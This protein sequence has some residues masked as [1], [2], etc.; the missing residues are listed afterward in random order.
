MMRRRGLLLFVVLLTFLGGLP[1]VSNA[2]GSDSSIP[3]ISNELTNYFFIHYNGT[4]QEIVLDE[5][6]T[7]TLI[8]W[9]DESKST[10]E[11]KINIQTD[12]SNFTEAKKIDV[13]N[14]L[15]KITVTDQKSIYYRL[16]VSD[17][18]KVDKV[19]PLELNEKSIVVAE[20]EN[21]TS[22]EQTEI[23]DEYDT[24]IDN[25]GFV[26]YL[27]D[28]NNKKTI[29]TME[30]YESLNSDSNSSINPQSS[31]SVTSST[32]EQSL[33]R[34]NTLS[35]ELTGDRPSV[36]YTTHVQDIGWQNI[37]MDGEL[38]GTE[39]KAK[40]LES[41]K[42]SVNSIQ[43]LGVKYSTHVQD[44]GWLNYVSDGAESGTTGK[45]RRLEAI[46][47][48]L[49]GANAD[50]YDIFYRVHAQDYGWMKWVKNGEMAGTS[51][52]S[53]RLEAI[54]IVITEKGTMPPAEEEEPVTPETT[55]TYKS[56][57][58][59]DGWSDAVSNGQLSGTVDQA[60]RIEAIQ[61]S[62][63][64]APYQGGI[65]YR[66]HVQDYGWL[67]SMSDGK[68]SGKPGENK[69]VEAVQISLTEN[70]ETQYDVYYRVY[71]ESF[72]WT[73]WVKNGE[74]A[75]KEGQSKQ[76][77]AMEI[78]LV[79][80]G[81]ES[82]GANLSEPSV[83]YTTHVET[84]GWLN[85]VSNGA[86][87]GTI[88]KAKRLE[89]IKIKLQDAPYSG[90][91]VYSTHVQDYG[92]LGSVSNGDI[93]GTSGQSKRLE[94]ITV[95]LSGDISNYYDVY[96]R[97]HAQDYGW[98]GWAK[99]GMK[100]GTEKRSK[101]LE[102][103]EIKL[104]PKGQGEAVSETA[105]YKKGMTIFLDSGHGG[106]DGGASAGG[107]READL[108]L[109]VAKKAQALLVSRGYNV[110]MS[111]TSDTTVELLDRPIM[112]NSLNV[113]LFVSIHTNSGSTT[114]TGIESYFYKYN[115]AYPPKINGTMHNN[116]ERISKSMTL[117]NFIQNNMVN[118]TG[119]RNRG[120]DGAAFEVI[121]ETVMPATLLEIGFISNTSERQ[122]LVTDSYQNLL[123]K[124]IA[125]GID[126]YFR[127]Y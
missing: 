104:V 124:A 16:D 123:A 40:R 27:T 90:D 20:N 106:T 44:L 38:S 79:E 43:N 85:Y 84:Y 6:V 66:T 116:P 78:V 51:G 22:I 45:A 23:V 34:L 87:S 42:V 73:S 58:Q 81:G 95:N 13:T 60:K 41:I 4:P 98:L 75:G 7:L 70:M 126:R 64:N 112:A 94:A 88:G 9:T 63:D 2:N 17:S 28:V 125:D 18:F 59:S 53:K 93:S 14:K 56:F 12:T 102:A 1:K 69:R 32:E 118:Y 113:D 19:V 8:G 77:E 15:N 65:S 109:S 111:R 5:S 80:K 52:E 55:V 110:I 103:I 127:T 76:L 107:V 68:P 99:N 31:A 61:I 30:E 101:R 49:T 97:V 83:V 25:K 48:E 115:P 121:R 50:K 47:I 72:G 21:G 119:A 89:A 10:V 11:G 120:T 54:K 35:K 3:E 57:V 74:T 24:V 39:G 114:A 105:A 82:P 36:Q 29:I 26:Y 117:A 91:I 100:A 86:M 96:Y 92:W 122:K 33:P 71:Q 62:L 67:E 108:N 37:V 46:K